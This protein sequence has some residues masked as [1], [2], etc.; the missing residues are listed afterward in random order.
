ML[1]VI[2][3]DYVQG[4]RVDYTGVVV[5]SL[6]SNFSRFPEIVVTEYTPL[7]GSEGAPTQWG[8]AEEK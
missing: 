8:F 3:F 7:T 6:D 2:D 4:Y 1:C 5:S